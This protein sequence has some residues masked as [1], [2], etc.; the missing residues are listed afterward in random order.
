VGY[1]KGQLNLFLLPLAAI[2]FPV[3]PCS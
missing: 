1:I 2:L 3:P